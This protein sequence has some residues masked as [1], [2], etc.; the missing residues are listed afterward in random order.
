MCVKNKALT[1]LWFPPGEVNTTK[2]MSMKKCKHKKAYAVIATVHYLACQQKRKFY[3]AVKKMT[4]LTFLF[5][6]QPI[7]ILKCYFF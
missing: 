1:V 7:L 4:G 6:C 5:S 2:N 3:L